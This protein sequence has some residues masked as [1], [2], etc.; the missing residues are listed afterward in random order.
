MQKQTRLFIFLGGFFVANALIAEFIG[1]KIF[2][3][4]KS[5]GFDP[6]DLS[7]FGNANL[8][9]NLTAGVLLWPE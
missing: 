8:G 9:F 4:E 2:S 5:L 7:F 3:L 1:V 6:F